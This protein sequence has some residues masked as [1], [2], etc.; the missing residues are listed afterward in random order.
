MLADKTLDDTLSARMA[1]DNLA[2]VLNVARDLPD[3]ARQY[4][5][6]SRPAAPD[7]AADGRL[8]P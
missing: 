6:H 4:S 7:A 2:I 1:D 8:M 3:Q 5:S